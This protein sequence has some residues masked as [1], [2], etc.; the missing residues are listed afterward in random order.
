MTAIENNP[1]TRTSCFFFKI[2]SGWLI[3]TGFLETSS[4]TSWNS[5]RGNF[6]SC[7]QVHI[8]SILLAGGFRHTHGQWRVVESL[9]SLTV[10]VVWGTAHSAGAAL[11][12]GLLWEAA[13]PWGQGGGLVLNGGTLRHR[14]IHCSSVAR[15]QSQLIVLRQGYLGDKNSGGDS[16]STLKQFKVNSTE[17]SSMANKHVSK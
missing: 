17:Q 1:W 10:P 12:F 2:Y 14:C 3:R 6:W 9:G 16:Q 8:T 15:H 4:S 13:G 11:G 5:L 7:D